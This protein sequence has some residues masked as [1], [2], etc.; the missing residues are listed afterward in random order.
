[1]QIKIQNFMFDFKYIYY[2][3]FFDL[4]YVLNVFIWHIIFSKHITGFN[5]LQKID[6]KKILFSIAHDIFVF[7]RLREKYLKTSFQTKNRKN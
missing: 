1:M 6:L 7:K 2:G 3:I 4:N 5:A